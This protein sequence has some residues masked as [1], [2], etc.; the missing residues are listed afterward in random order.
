MTGIGIPTSQ[1]NKPRTDCS[2]R[3]SLANVEDAE[4]VPAGPLTE[5]MAG[6]LVIGDRAPA[7]GTW[8]RTHSSSVQTLDSRS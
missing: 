3:L 2:F 7:E 5:R 8:A 1:S 4:R 6:R